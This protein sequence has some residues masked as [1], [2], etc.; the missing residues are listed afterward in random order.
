MTPC[1][2]NFR[3]FRRSIMA[4]VLGGLAM[5]A[6]SPPPPPPTPAAETEVLVVPVF[7]QAKF[8]Q[9]QTDMTYGQVADLLESESTRQEST[10][11]EGESEY[12]LPFLTSWYYWENE[13]GSFIKAGFVEKKLVEKVSENLPK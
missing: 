5:A 12:V 11:N 2:L 4:L 9:I 1:K 8:D 6:C 10:Y 3:T 13:D 7:T